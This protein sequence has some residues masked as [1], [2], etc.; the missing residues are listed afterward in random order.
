M[1]LKERRKLNK[2]AIINGRDEFH[3]I[4]LSKNLS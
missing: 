4:K 2:N 1:L 3:K